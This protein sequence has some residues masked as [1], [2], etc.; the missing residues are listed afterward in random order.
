MKSLKGYFLDDILKLIDTS[1]YSIQIRSTNMKS[2]TSVYCFKKGTDI[3]H[4][5]T[6]HDSLCDGTPADFTSQPSRTQTII[7]IVGNL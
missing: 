5:F 7:S 6:W 4:D 2:E 1:E 3:C